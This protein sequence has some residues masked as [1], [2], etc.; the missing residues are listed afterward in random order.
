MI[1]IFEYDYENGFEIN[2]YKYNK[3]TT[4]LK[5]EQ[6]IYSQKN[7]LIQLQTKIN[8][9]DFYTSRKYYYDNENNLIR[10]DAFEKKDGYIYSYLYEYNKIENKKTSYL[11]NDDGKKLIGEYYYNEDG[12]VI[13]VKSIERMATFMTQQGTDFN[14]TNQL[15][16]NRYNPD[17]TLFETTI[18]LEGKKVQ[19]TRH[20]YF[21]EGSL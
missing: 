2:K 15:R 8:N 19:M 10:T 20:Y 1:T 11:K 12:Q 14:T 17:K 7:Q 9:K 21:N 6:K 18:Y 5:I 16:E 3:D 4:E 13:K